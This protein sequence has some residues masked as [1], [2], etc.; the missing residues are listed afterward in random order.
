MWYLLQ[1]ETSESVDLEIYIINRYISPVH[2]KDVFINKINSFKEMKTNSI[3]Y[4]ISN[5]IPNFHYFVLKL[6]YI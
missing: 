3:P 5:C 1:T 4:Q 2:G 6:E